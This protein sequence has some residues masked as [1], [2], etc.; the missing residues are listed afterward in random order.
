VTA[1]YKYWSVGSEAT[2]HCLCQSS[3]SE[4]TDTR[5]LFHFLCSQFQNSCS[6]LLQILEKILFHIIK[7]HFLYKRCVDFTLLI[8]TICYSFILSSSFTFSTVFPY[9]KTI[10]LIWISCVLCDEVLIINSE[11]ETMW[12]SDTMTYFRVLWRDVFAGMNVRY[13]RL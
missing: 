9:L 7:Q 11:L 5:I 12:K 2:Y 10:F 4:S 3:H 13:E 1:L 6:T 8:A